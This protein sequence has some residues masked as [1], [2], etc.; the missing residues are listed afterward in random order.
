MSVGAMAGCLPM[1]RHTH[2]GC[3]LL[4]DCTWQQRFTVLPSLRTHASKHLRASH[5]GQ[6]KSS[7]A[8]HLRCRSES[9]NG[10][11]SKETSVENVVIIGS[12]P[13]G[14]TAAIYAA[15]ANLKPVVFE[16]YQVGGVRGGQLMTTTEV[17]NFP[18][19]PEG[20][21]GPDL[22]D[23]MRAQA[24][25][26]GSELLTEDVEHVDLGNRPFTV[27]TSDTEVKAHSIIIA[28]GATAKRLGIPSEEKFWSQGISACAICD[29]A[30]YSFRNQELAVVGG[31]DT[32][33][34]EAIYLT[35]YGT[36]VHLL[37][38]GEKLRA[39]RSMQ[40][41][42]LD[43]KKVTVHF[44]TTVDDAYPD[45]K[46]ALAGLHIKDTKTGEGSKLPVKGLFYGIG[47]QPNSQL[48]AGQID[49][50]QHGYVKVHDGVQT[51][52]EGVYAAGDL[53][54][55][56]WRQAITAAGSGCMAAL[57]A[58]RYLTTHNL[59]R[60]Y[61]TKEQDDAKS[62]QPEEKQKA[63]AEAE[64][65]IHQDR[66]KGQLALRKLYH[67]SDRVIVVLYTSPT[68][69]PCRTLKPIF[70]KVVDEYEKQV[71]LVEI[72]IEQ[73]PQIAEAA[74]VQSTPTIQ[75]FKDKERIQHLPGVKMKSE[76]RKMISEA[77]EE[78]ASVP[79]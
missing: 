36:M 59:A 28:T 12:G 54:D 51:S 50:D 69:G 21:T 41:R 23:K 76:Y 70:S 25:R 4:R 35:K 40:D 20:V 13:A 34:E 61:H 56:E 77:L 62:L 67:E 66:H 24:E 29:G 49:L 68:C 30:S 72:D 33:V 53:F 58:E 42:A 26:W 55:V 78:K 57:S 17:E 8:Q 9:H 38:R 39:S 5:K 22:M 14:Y 71:H 63:D 1:H 7:R 44:N 75:M 11:G 16:G 15:R 48:V 32:A 45:G 3:Q 10:N 73:D 60:E 52:V 19:F 79:A 47:H 46:G 18:G 64:F 2:A 6:C 43:H 74:G 27:R 37:A 65:D 31:G